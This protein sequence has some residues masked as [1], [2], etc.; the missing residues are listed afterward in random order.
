MIKYYCSDGSRVSE[1]TIKKKLSEA[2]RKKYWNGHP[3]CESC[4]L[5][6][7]QGSAHLLPKARLKSLHLTEKIWDEEFFVPAC[8]ECNLL[9]EAIYSDEIK[10]SMCY[11]KLLK[12][13]EKYDPERY[14]KLIVG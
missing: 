4:G 3:V 5:K 1:A 7:A 9:L 12:L 14:K 11:S 6:Q 8:H 2:Y 10:N 13:T